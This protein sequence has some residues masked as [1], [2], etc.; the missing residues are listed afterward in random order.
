MFNFDWICSV[1]KKKETAH[2]DYKKASD[3]EAEAVRAGVKNFPGIGCP[4]ELMK[5]NNL[6]W[7]MNLCRS[8]KLKS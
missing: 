2:P 7:K 1:C 5:E 6:S 8:P 4:I 3:A